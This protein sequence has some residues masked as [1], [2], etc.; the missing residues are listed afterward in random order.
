[1]SF[2]KEGYRLERVA[3][4]VPIVVRVIWLRLIT[5]LD[6]DSSILFAPHLTAVS[7]ST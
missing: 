6:I 1:M 7:V 5:S 2:A 4:I 3:L